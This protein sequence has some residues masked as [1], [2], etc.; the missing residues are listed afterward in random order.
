MRSFTQ[1]RFAE[2]AFCLKAHLG[3]C[4]G[5]GWT[6]AESRSRE[7]ESLLLCW[8]LLLEDYCPLLLRLSK[9]K[10]KHSCCSQLLWI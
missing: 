1:K 4:Q 8:C 6:L 3:P 9:N 10:K 2:S 5:V 7:A